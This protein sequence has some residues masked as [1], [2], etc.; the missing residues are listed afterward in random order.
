MWS[1]RKCV[2]VTVNILLFMVAMNF[3]HYGQLILPVI[4]LILF[5][6][7]KFRFYVS[8]IREFV[9]LCLFAIA[10]CFFSYDLGFYCVMGFV[11]PMAYYIG[12]NLK[13]KNEE[14]VKKLIYIVAFGMAVHLLFNFG[15]ELCKWNFDL[16][17]IFRKKTHYDIWTQS[18]TTRT[19]LSLNYIFLLSCFYYLLKHEPDKRIKKSG[20]LLFVVT[21]FYCI[22]LARRLILVLA[23]LCIFAGLSIENKDRK[24]SINPRHV[25]FAASL[26]FI[27]VMLYSF[28]FLH[29]KSILDS[30]AIFRKFKDE[31][32]S[33]GRINILMESL[34]LYPKYMFGGQRI[35]GTTGEVIHDLWGDIYDYAG[36]VPFLMMLIVS[37]SVFAR[38][39]SVLISK[40]MSKDI[41]L[42]LVDVFMCS[43][44]MLFFE[45]IMT[46]ASLFFTCYIITVTGIIDVF[47]KD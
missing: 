41:K 30:F 14:N 42:L 32:F 35:S 6:D 26:M 40:R 27:V 16:V 36:I 19:G 7:R 23:I 11:L 12:S 9:L 22:A 4:C 21:S 38:I 24:I 8:D 44:I 39:I 37:V 28:D 33:S 15:Y 20:I 2:D 3:M 10:F 5:I 34:K 29:C 45:P 47:S 18:M 13:E 31:G 46:G 43:S 25:I 17:K 1:D